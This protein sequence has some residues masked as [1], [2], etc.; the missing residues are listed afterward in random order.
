MAEYDPIGAMNSKQEVTERRSR[1]SLEYRD[2]QLRSLGIPMFGE[3]GS[4]WSRRHVIGGPVPGKSAN[5]ESL[6]RDEGVGCNLH[7]QDATYKTVQ[8]ATKIFFSVSRCSCAQD[9]RAPKGHA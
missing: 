9:H 7:L 1:L 6:A 5:E 3:L 8:G 4:R 2:H